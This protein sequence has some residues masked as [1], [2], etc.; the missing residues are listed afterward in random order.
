MYAKGPS[1]F[2]WLEITCVGRSGMGDPVGGPAPV[3]GLFSWHSP[4]VAPPVG[5]P[6]LKAEELWMGNTRNAESPPFPLSLR[7]MTQI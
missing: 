6:G 3:R 2:S 1:S 5:K 4:T 7:L